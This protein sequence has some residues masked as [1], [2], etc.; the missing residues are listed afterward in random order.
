MANF[1][2]FVILQIRPKQ[3][4]KENRARKVTQTP[5]KCSATAE[6]GRCPVT[7]V[8]APCRALCK[9]VTEQEERKMLNLVYPIAWRV[10]QLVPILAL[11]VV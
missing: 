7:P 10:S 8:T 1:V 2:V 6:S 9:K 4:S 5:R 3:P 11:A